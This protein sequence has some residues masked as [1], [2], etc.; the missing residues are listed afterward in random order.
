M[1]V[2]GDVRNTSG[3]SSTAFD[4]TFTLTVHD[5]RLLWA[6]AADR[7]RRTPGLTEEDVEETIGTVEDPAIA[8]CISVLAAPAQIPGC[9]PERF[10]VRE[11]NGVA[12]SGGTVVQLAQA[13]RTAVG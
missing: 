10:E 12:R 2:V 9:M 7:L 3:G 13:Q 11:A 8:E 6:A 5:A 4:V 1:M